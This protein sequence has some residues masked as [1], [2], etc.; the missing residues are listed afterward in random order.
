MSSRRVAS[1]H[2][3]RW[4]KSKRIMKIIQTIL[5]LA[6][7]GVSAYAAETSPPAEKSFDAPHGMKVSVK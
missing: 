7:V 3:D 1:C 2:R 4:T 6:L 5:A